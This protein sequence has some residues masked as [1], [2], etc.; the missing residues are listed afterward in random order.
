MYEGRGEGGIS[1]SRQQ[2]GEWA[3][4]GGLKMKMGFF[5]WA[6]ANV[7]GF[8][9]WLDTLEAS[10][11]ITKFCPLRS[12]SFYVAQTLSQAKKFPGAVS[13]SPGH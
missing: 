5:F 4:V 3:S 12:S 8:K 10:L 13:A 11:N 2:E 9:R 1:I 6:L 7:W